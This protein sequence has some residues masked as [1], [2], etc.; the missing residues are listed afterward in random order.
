MEIVVSFMGECIIIGDF[1]E[2]F[3][4]SKRMG[5]QIN[6]APKMLS[7]L[8]FRL[9]GHGLSGVTNRVPNL[10]KL[11]DSWLW[12]V[13]CI[14]SLLLRV[15]FWKKYPDH[16]PIMLLEHRVDYGSIPF[17]IFHSWFELEDFDRIVH[18]S[19]FISSFGLKESNPWVIFKKKLQ[20][21]KSNMRVRNTNTHD[22]LSMKKRIYK[23]RSSLWMHV[24]WRM[25]DRLLSENNGLP[26]L[27]DLVDL[28]HR[29]HL[30]M[31]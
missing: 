13:F 19:W 2:V 10:L 22:Q 17:R 8:I 26:F 31:V 1:N 15:W 12:R 21:L 6:L 20:F 24:S 7:W 28:D 23:I 30:E 4:G 3:D 27:K 9:E 11:I 18:T 16:C 14:I 29:S 5:Y 25:T